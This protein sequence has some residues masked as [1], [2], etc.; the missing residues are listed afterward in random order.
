MNKD[1]KKW[2]RKV[3]FVSEEVKE[4]LVIA[5]LIVIPVSSVIILALILKN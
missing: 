3:K 5:S 1:D 4:V 2:F